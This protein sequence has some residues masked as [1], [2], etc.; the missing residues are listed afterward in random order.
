MNAALFYLFIYLKFHISETRIRN[1][2]TTLNSPLK[3]LLSQLLIFTIGLLDDL[4]LLAVSQ[5]GLHIPWLQAPWLRHCLQWLAPMI[6]T[7]TVLHAIWQ[8]RHQFQ[9]SRKPLADN[10]VV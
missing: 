1:M 3:I 5:W 8:L 6:L 2:K 4:L 9:T 7:A 10:A